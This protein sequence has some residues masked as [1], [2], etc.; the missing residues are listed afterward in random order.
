MNFVDFW[1]VWI[2]G[3]EGYSKRKVVG[4]KRYSCSQNVPVRHGNNLSYLPYL[5]GVFET[6]VPPLPQAKCL[7]RFACSSLVSRV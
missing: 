3:F 7:R 4:L 5:L 6:E 1:L 2:V